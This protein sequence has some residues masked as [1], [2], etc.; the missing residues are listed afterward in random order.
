VALKG[1]NNLEARF[2]LF[3]RNSDGKLSPEEFMSGPR[4]LPN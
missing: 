3:D 4:Q 2:K 1:Q